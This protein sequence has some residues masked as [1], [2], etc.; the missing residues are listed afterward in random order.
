MSRDTATFFPFQS[1]AK[2]VRNPAG[3]RSPAAHPGRGAQ[4]L[5]HSP[6][7]KKRTESKGQE[8]IEIINIIIFFSSFTRTSVVPRCPNPG[9][10]YPRTSLLFWANQTELGY[11]LTRLPSGD[12]A[13]RVLG[14]YG[15]AG[16]PPAPHL[17]PAAPGREKITP[18][19]C[20]ALGP[21]S[22]HS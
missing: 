16:E 2:C 21:G 17:Q 3:T 7:S 9:R 11:T 12:K 14:R 20:K 1:K 8:E 22:Q 15:L 10:A 5:A 6:R 18:H 19:P 4:P 13:A